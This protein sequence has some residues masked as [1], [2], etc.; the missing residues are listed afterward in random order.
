[1][2]S[3]SVLIDANALSD[4]AA[5]ILE[6]AGVSESKARLVATS[7]VAANLRGVDSHGVQL[8]PF[9][10]E[11]LETGDIDKTA[12]GHVI[13]ESGVCLLYDAENGLG[14]PVSEIAC[15]HGVRIAKEQ[16]L[17]IVVVRES[18]HFGAAAFWAQKYAREGLIGIVLCNA[19]P[20]VPPWQGKQPRFGTNPICMAVPGDRWLLDMATTTVAAGKIYKAMVN[21]HETIPPGWA[22]D[23]E[24]VPTTS[25]AMALKGLVSPLG[26]Y[27]GSG[28]AVM[29][30]ILCA[31]LSGG[32][33]STELGGI[34]IRG[35]NMRVSQTFI[36]IDVARFVPLDEFNARMEKLVET[37]KSTPPAKDYE[38]VLVAGE[39]EWRME[40][41]R[42]VAGIPIE[43]GTW[44][45][46]TGAAAR[47][48]V[49]IPASQMVN[50]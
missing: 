12:D 14:A 36:G 11:R 28:L 22:T 50:S 44:K 10:I 3:P 33:M 46:L 13:S 18:N 4:F 29:V 48:G 37:V 23:A 25:V 6:G 19:S 41:Q 32:A 2:P 49:A 26:G 31:V 16:G 5:S 45:L 30:E 17:S 15:R 38:E 34:R 47:L 1:M 24:G 21:G 35:R 43:P 39:P 20:M 8:L 7:L 27:K 40:R 42:R 9:Y